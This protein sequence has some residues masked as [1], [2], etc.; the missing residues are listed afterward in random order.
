MKPS[1]L[2]RSFKTLGWLAVLLIIL[3]LLYVI[4]PV[5]TADLNYQYPLVPTEAHALENYIGDKEKNTKDIKEGNAATI[6]WA[7]STKTKTEYS[8]VY[9]HGFSA[10]HAEGGP[11]PK[12]IADHF[13]MN[14]F[15][16]RLSGHGIKGKEGML[17]FSP[18]SFTKTALEAIAIGKSLGEKVI[19]MGTSTGATVGLAIMAE[20]PS[21]FGAIF[22]SA[23]IDLV[24]SKSDLLTKPFG[25]SIARKVIGSNYY[26]F[27]PPP[28]AEQYWTH[29]Y[30]LEATVALQTL[31]N[32]T[33][34][35][36]T[37]AKIEQPVLL[38]SY[39]KDENNQDDVVSVA[40]IEE[41]YEQLATKV[42]KKKYVKLPNVEA[43]AMCSPL[44]SKDIISP[45]EETKNYL[46]ENLGLSPK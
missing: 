11:I 33:M 9:L 19:L 15:L 30:P 34:H 40:A 2:K 4:W 10:S 39:Y 22:Y 24:D 44:Y 26:S 16:S 36:K 28:G 17:E 37:F 23:N 18:Q 27:D 45:Y 7:D 14:L 41:C 12:Q 6:V 29:I 3:L 13:G 42:G 32:T 20:D 21:I 43:H 35:E 31:M 38:L 1:I 5:T 8:L 25:L 46:I